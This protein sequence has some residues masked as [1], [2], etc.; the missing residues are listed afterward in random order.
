M[1]ITAEYTAIHQAIAEEG[2]RVGVKPFCIR[3]LLAV[4]ERGGEATT[5]EIEEDLKADDAAVRRAVLAL[6]SKKLARGCGV[7]GGPRR[8]GVRTV[9][10]LTDEGRAVCG[11]ITAACSEEFVA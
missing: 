8:P 10:Q 6:Y 11:R 5:L 7:D 9:V 2:K 1:S 3:V 4:H